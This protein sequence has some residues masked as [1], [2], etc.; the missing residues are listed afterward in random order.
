VVSAFSIVKAIVD[1]TADRCQDQPAWRRDG[2]ADSA[3]NS[4]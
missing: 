3:A 2:F 1:A 4:S